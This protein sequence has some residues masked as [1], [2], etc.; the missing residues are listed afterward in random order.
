MDVRQEIEERFVEMGLTRSDCQ[1][2]DARSYVG[3]ILGDGATMREE[4]DGKR[5]G[6]LIKVVDTNAWIFEHVSMRVGHGVRSSEHVLVEQKH[7]SSSRIIVADSL[8][9]S[10]TREVRLAPLVK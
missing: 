3:S 9:G 6:C 1:T 8:C 5:D 7:F 2:V 10:T 4:R